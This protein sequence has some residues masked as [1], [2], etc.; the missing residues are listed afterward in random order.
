MGK[1]DKYVCDGQ[2]DI[3][4]FV[5]EQAYQA[6]KKPV[7]KNSCNIT[8]LD[9]KAHTDKG[10]SIPGKCELLK[11]VVEENNICKHSEHTCNKEELWKVADSLE[12]EC[13]HTCC[14][15]CKVR[16]CG[17]RCNGSAEPKEKANK[18]PNCSEAEIKYIL[19]ILRIDACE[20]M[21]ERIYKDIKGGMPDEQLCKLLKYCYRDWRREKGVE[22]EHVFHFPKDMRYQSAITY[23]DGMELRRK[24]GDTHGCNVMP[25]S[26]VLLLIKDMIA[27][28]DYVEVPQVKTKPTLM[29]GYSCEH[30][31]TCWCNRYGN[32][33]PMEEYKTELIK[34]YSCAGC[35]Y[36][37]K[38]SPIH[39]GKCK[40]DCRLRK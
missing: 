38:E 22:H 24:P 5:E 25:W 13:P 36:Y 14:R 12:T 7:T 27:A 21:R 9:C 16:M 20:Y 11:E 6:S 31:H 23:P 29:P 15:S 28:G 33:L 2:M 39:G 32:E 26:H 30:D 37:C 8:G 4:S 17:A 18:Y 1:L 35:C 3:F 19:P 40:W 10:C 34:G